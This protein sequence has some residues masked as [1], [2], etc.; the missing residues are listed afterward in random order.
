MTPGFKRGITGSSLEEQRRKVEEAFAVGLQTISGSQRP[1]LVFDTV[2]RLESA[3]DPTQQERGFFDDT[4]S[5]MGWLIYQITQFRGGVV[6]LL[7][8]RAPRFYRR[9]AEAIADANNDRSRLQLAPIELQHIDLEALDAS[10]MR[11]FFALRLEREPQL[12]RLL[13]AELQNL[14]SERTHGNPLLL[15]LAL[16]SLLEAEDPRKIKQ[17]LT[18]DPGSPTVE[19]ALIKAFMNSQNT[20]RQ[21]LIRLLALTRNGLFDDLLRV[22]EPQSAETLIAELKKMESLPFMKVRDIWA[23]R[24]GS[25]TRRPAARIFYM[26]P[27]TPSATN[28]CSNL[29]RLRKTAGGS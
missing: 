26:M 1:V 23:S 28:S 22:L 15:D 18:D 14:L 11:E 4:A 24:P 27:C 29:S 6:M 25:E 20:D 10:E 3:T 12:V 19:Q 7:G 21:V 5:V 8:R 2:E 17:A 16:L 13:D 9:L